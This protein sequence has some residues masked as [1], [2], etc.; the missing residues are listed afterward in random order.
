MPAELLVSHIMTD[1]SHTIV[2]V[3]V[4]VRV[5]L[6]GFTHMQRHSR[7]VPTHTH[8]HIVELCLPANL[9]MGKLTGHLGRFA[10]GN[11]GQGASRVCFNTFQSNICITHAPPVK[12]AAHARQLCSCHYFLYSSFFSLPHHHHQFARHH[13]HQVESFVLWRI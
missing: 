3:S 8:P 4:S 7:A 5:R 9:D 13:S 6:T 10:R 1:Y 2:P 11:K 12:W